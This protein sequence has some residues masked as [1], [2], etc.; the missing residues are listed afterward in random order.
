MATKTYPII[1]SAPM[2][3]ALL[4]DR[5]TQTRRLVTKQWSN[6][7]VRFD[8]GERSL[9]WVRET[10]YPSQHGGA[11]Y[12]A[13]KDEASEL[14]TE[15]LRRQSGERWRPSIRMPRWASRLALEVTDVRIQSLQDITKEDAIAEGM[16][17]SPGGSWL[18]SAAA[19]HGLPTARDAYH[20]LWESLHGPGSWD[21]NPEIAALSFRVRHEN[22]DTLAH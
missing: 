22:V 15:A 20:E 21:E 7:K 5:K 18:S 14:S 16:I 8:Q 13:H 9:L 2:V 12:R 4:E 1:F 10:W 17:P 11:A 6:L 19:S 3:R